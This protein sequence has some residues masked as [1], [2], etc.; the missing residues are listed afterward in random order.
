MNSKSFANSIIPETHL[1][2]TSISLFPCITKVVCVEGHFEDAMIEYGKVG[3]A[4]KWVESVLLIWLTAWLSSWGAIEEACK[5]CET[6]GM[7]PAYKGSDNDMCMRRGVGCRK[8][9]RDFVKLCAKAAALHS[10]L[11]DVVEE[12]RVLLLRMEG[13]MAGSPAV[14]YSRPASWTELGHGDVW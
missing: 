6:V 1:N 9:G 7:V 4:C 12:I 11:C 13:G 3:S 14:A 5:P 2:D 8:C 10:R